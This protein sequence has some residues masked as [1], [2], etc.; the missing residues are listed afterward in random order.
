MVG[1]GILLAASDP[2]FLPRE[3]LLFYKRRVGAK[4]TQRELVALVIKVW[5]Y[6]RTGKIVKRLTWMK[7]TGEEFSIIRWLAGWL[8]GWLD[9]LKA[10][11][12]L[13]RRRGLALNEANPLN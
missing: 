12:T 3:K 8:A 11:Q 10:V 9:S 5:N 7:K 4:L 1:P 13:Y 6:R 2:V